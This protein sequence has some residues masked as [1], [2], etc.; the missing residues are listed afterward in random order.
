[1]RV[2]LQLI[3]GA[4]LLGTVAAGGYWLNQ[5]EVVAEDGEAPP[6]RAT[7]VDV[8]SVR[9]D[10]VRDIFEA[11]GTTRARES[12]DV[13]AETS[14]RVT[15]IAFE[16]GDRVTEGDILIELD[17]ERERAELREKQAQLRDAQAQFERARELREDTGAVSQQEVDTLEASL[18]VARA[19]VGLAET[20]VRDRVVRAPFDGVLGLREI[21]RGAYV[22]PETL[23]T[24]LDETEVLRL[25]FSVP[26]RFLAEIRPGMEARARARGFPERTFDGE[27]RRVDSRVD[28]VTRSVRVQTE[29]ENEDGRLKPGMFMT[30]QLVLRTRESPVIPEEALILEGEERY[31]Y[32]VREERA[33]RVTVETGE[34]TVGRV[35]ILD[36]LEKGELVVTLGHQKI[37]DGARVSIRRGPDE[38]DALAEGH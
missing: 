14:G 33:H 19:Q 4:V 24:T 15:R 29:L 3:I 10:E 20:R 8:A 27:V 26:E 11:T 5:A 31:V 13:V 34:R 6:E 7:A 25:N 21:S 28:P 35:E 2:V 30:V 1:M 22:D 38:N 12:V 9:I 36:G 37:R 16:E 32:V 23:I 17:A 18:S